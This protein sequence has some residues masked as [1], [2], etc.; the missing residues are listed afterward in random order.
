MLEAVSF[1]KELGDPAAQTAIHSSRPDSLL[2]LTY[3]SSKKMGQV[4]GLDQMTAIS[5]LP[6]TLPGDK[7]WLL[8]DPK[9]W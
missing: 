5:K 6:A 4:P 8:K 3:W 7:R 9:D 2:E 1:S